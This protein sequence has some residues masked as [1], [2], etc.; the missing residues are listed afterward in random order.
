M[1]VY[2]LEQQENGEKPDVLD[3]ID[4][5]LARKDATSVLFVSDDKNI[6]NGKLIVQKAIAR[7]VDSHIYR[8]CVCVRVCACTG[9][10][11]ISAAPPLRLAVS[12]A[13]SC[14]PR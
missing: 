9:D 8:A 1:Y 10:I 4:V 13:P 14:L 11:C 12:L 7:S 2:I 3:S 6:P 5:V